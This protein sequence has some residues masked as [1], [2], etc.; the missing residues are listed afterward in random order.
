MGG[1]ELTYD[2]GKD[3]VFVANGKIIY[4]ISDT[5]NAVVA[6]IPLEAFASASPSALAYD[7][8]KNE[9]F[10]AESGLGA[11]VSVISDTTNTVV[12]TM[13]VGLQ[14]VSIAYD[15]GKNELFVANFGSSSIS[16]IQTKLTLWWQ[17]YH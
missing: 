13:P 10:V 5:T 9:I 7:S 8:G 3:E 15:Y 17:Q 14:P 6:S 4:V 1:E 2:G 11:R 12:A 16:V